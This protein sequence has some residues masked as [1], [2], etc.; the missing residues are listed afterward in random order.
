[1]TPS[2][3][4]LVGPRFRSRVV[5]Q[6]VYADGARLT[7]LS[8]LVDNGQFGLRLAG[9]LPLAEVAVAHERLAA[10]GVRGRLVL[11]P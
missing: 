1:M 2:G 3:G 8:A 4:A 11:V 6:E 5:V 7:E 10:G 9:R